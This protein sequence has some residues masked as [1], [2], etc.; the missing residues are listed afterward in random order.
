MTGCVSSPVAYQKCF[1]F[2]WHLAPAAGLCSAGGGGARS[3]LRL[4]T[5]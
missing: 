2:W 5:K 1:S 4:G 3:L